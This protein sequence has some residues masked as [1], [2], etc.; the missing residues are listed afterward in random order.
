M[1]SRSLEQHTPF[2]ADDPEPRWLS[3][4]TRRR[5]T[6]LVFSQGGSLALL[7]VLT[8]DIRRLD[9][10]VI[11]DRHA[12]RPRL[13]SAMPTADDLALSPDGRTL[14]VGARGEVS[15]T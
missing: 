14:L 11:T 4:G 3:A 10:R 12:A 8:D 1:V 2:G 5:D 7:D 13:V 15:S 9:V 6:R